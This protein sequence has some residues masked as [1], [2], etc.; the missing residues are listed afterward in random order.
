MTIR[1]EPQVG[2]PALGFDIA[3]RLSRETMAMAPLLSV[4]PDC[5]FRERLDLAE[6]IDNVPDRNSRRPF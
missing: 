4:G 2:H 5:D 6:E 3:R 1:L